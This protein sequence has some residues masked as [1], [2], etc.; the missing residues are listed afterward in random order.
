MTRVHVGAAMPL[1]GGRPA[2][3]AAEVREGRDPQGR[4][5]FEFH[6]GHVGRVTPYGVEDARAALAE[7]MTR[8][9]PVRPC[10]IIDVGTPQGLALHQSCRGAW[11]PSMHRA[12]AF[13]GTGPRG[14][15]FASFLQAYS[16][17]RV[18]FAPDLKHR[19][20]LDRALV[21]FGTGKGVAAHGVELT[22]EE[23]ALVLALG[24]A[25][26]WPRHGPPARPALKAREAVTPAKP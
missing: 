25:L 7:L 18:T 12:H 24:L 26:T 16:A 8:L 15:L 22:S 10:A 9:E 14:P 6:V 5:A 19:S 2:L 11:S 20:D 1:K 21:F 23:E 13:P 17:G 4:A 3:V